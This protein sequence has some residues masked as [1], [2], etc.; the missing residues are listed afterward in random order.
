M[1]AAIMQPYIFPYIGY[2]NL[3]HASD[4]FVFYDDVN[5][6]KKGWVN[7]NRM[8]N[9]GAGDGMLFTLPVEKASRNKVISEIKPLVSPKWKNSFYNKL[10]Y[11][12][13]KAPF[14]GEV[15]DVLMD[16]FSKDYSDIS[17]LIAESFVSIYSYLNVE[18]EFFRSSVL[19]PETR[20]L[21][22]AD[23]LIEITKKAGAD[24]YVNAPGGE[25]IYS[26]EYFNGKGVKLLFV[27]PEIREYD[28]G[29]ESFVPWLSIIDVLM[30]CSKVDV[31][32]LMSSYT[33]E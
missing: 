22:K 26:K 16:P 19:S 7:R 29:V 1:R 5:Y 10:Y 6:V 14:F 30:F 2:F 11:N 31:K 8:L 4:F 12:Y 32:Y 9:K 24:V 18:F 25:E 21:D 17:G 13:K 20:G 3:I 15:V 33:L 28:Q 27:K 23:R